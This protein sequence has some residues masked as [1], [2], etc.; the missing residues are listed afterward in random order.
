LAQC[1]GTARHC[2]A[3]KIAIIRSIFSPQGTPSAPSLPA[4][5]VVFESS[6]DNPLSPLNALLI[7]NH[8]NS[9]GSAQGEPSVGSEAATSVR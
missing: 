3:I 1:G 5:E 4:S 6:G 2:Q 7:V 9:I 8:L